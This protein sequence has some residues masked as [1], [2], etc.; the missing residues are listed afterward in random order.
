M[1]TVAGPVVA[2]SAMPLVG[3]YSCEVK[4]SVTFADHEAGDEAGDDGAPDAEV[5]G[6]FEVAQ[7]DVR[8]ARRSR[9]S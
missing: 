2:L 8:E 3:A 7:D 5:V 6:H 4:Y 1:M 9:Q